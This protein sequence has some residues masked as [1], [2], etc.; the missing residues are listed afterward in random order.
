M[1]LSS[2]STNHNDSRIFPP[3]LSKNKYYTISTPQRLI[4][5]RDHFQQ[6][7]PTAE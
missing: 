2:D 3:F 4:K 1:V 5:E 7:R 6:E